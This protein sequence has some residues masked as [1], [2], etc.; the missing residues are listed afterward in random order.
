MVRALLALEILAAY[1]FN[2]GKLLSGNGDLTPV[3][4]FAIKPVELS[5]DHLFPLGSFPTLNT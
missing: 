5:D 1:I 2:V 4:S 3:I